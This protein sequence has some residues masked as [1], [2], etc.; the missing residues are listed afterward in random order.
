MDELNGGF[1]EL[2]VEEFNLQYDFDE[3]KFN[4]FLAKTGM[5][6][7]S[8]RE[9]GLLTRKEYEENFKASKVTAFRDL[10]ELIEKGYV[11]ADG[12]GKNTKYFLNQ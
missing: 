5:E 3:S 1:D 6:L 7:D 4:R 11:K 9:K 2:S 8:V 12:Q 10:N